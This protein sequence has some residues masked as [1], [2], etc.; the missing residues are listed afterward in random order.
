MRDNCHLKMVGDILLCMLS[1]SILCGCQGESVPGVNETDNYSEQFMSQNSTTSIL[2]EDMVSGSN[3]ESSD[4]EEDGQDHEEESERREYTKED[5]ERAWDNRLGNYGVS[6][7]ALPEIEV[8]EDEEKYEIPSTNGEDNYLLT[9]RVI[10]MGGAEYESINA[11]LAETMEE[12]RM[13][14][15]AEG[16]WGDTTAALYICRLDGRVIS[17]KNSEYL[18]FSNAATFDMA[19]G[20]KLACADIFADKDT[21]E[22]IIAENLVAQVENMSDWRFHYSNQ[23]REQYVRIAES[24]SFE[25]E[26]VYQ[27]YLD[28]ESFVIEV[29]VANEGCLVVLPY[30]EYAYLF[31]PQYLPGDGIAYYRSNNTGTEHI[32]F[33]GVITEGVELIESDPSCDYSVVYPDVMGY[34]INDGTE[35]YICIYVGGIYD[36]EKRSY[37]CGFTENGIEPLAEFEG[38]KYFYVPEELREWIDTLP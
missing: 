5:L 32:E 36:H 35:E 11:G 2:S 21:A 19:T 26:A 27:W 23:K 10:Q 13:R 25:N 31:K 1:V 29:T 24:F 4:Q 30:R 38:G 6:L 3:I 16:S 37:L 17:V 20:E 34:Y 28:G 33:N 18:L 8:C 22:A 9:V 12:E 15:E 14:Y 7:T